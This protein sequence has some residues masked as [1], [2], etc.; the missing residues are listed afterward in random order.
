MTSILQSTLPRT[1]DASQ[2]PLHLRDYWHVILRRRRLVAIVFLLIVAAGAARVLLVKRLYQ[3]T[4]Q[5]LIERQLPNVL[6]FENSTVAKE[7]WEDFYQTQYRLLQSRL[8]ARKVIERLN[9][10]QDPDF[11]DPSTPVAPPPSATGTSPAMEMLIDTFLDRLKVEPVKNSQLLT[12]GFRSYRPQLAAQVANTLTQIYIQQVL[13]FHNSTSAETGAWL[14]G[15]T[16]EQARKVEEAERALQKF[17]EG[18]G[19]VNIEERRT[20]LEQKLKDLGSSLT[21]AKTRRLDK[22]ALYRQMRSSANPEE[23]PEVI[24]SG[25][26]QSLRSE[27][28][29]LERQGAQLTAKGYLEQHPEVVKVREQIDA[30]RQKIAAE[31][32]RFVRGAENDYRVAADQERSVAAALES[33][34]SE[35]L[36]LSQRSLK[37]DS[38]KRDLDASKKLSDNMLTREKE[39]NV[40][41][42]AEVS[43]VRVVDA[44]AEP[45]DP[46]R[47]RPIRDT[48]LSI[49]LGLVLAVGAAFFRDY[50]DNSVG[51]P[52]D[53]RR[54]GLPLLGIIPEGNAKNGG[55]V[56]TNG[57]RK[58]P[59]SEGYRVLRAA[60]HGPAGQGQV[61]V[62]T[63]TLP[64]EGKSLTAVNLALSLASA[65]ERVLLVDADMRRPTLNTLLGM[66]RTPGLCE[67]LTGVAGLEAAVQRVPGTRLRILT[68]GTPVE[69]NPADLLATSGFRE[70]LMTLRA[71]YDRIVLDTPP[72]GALAD[73]LTLSPL[74][75][76]VLVVAR[77]GKVT[78]SALSQALERLAQAR[79]HVVGVVLNRARPERHQYDYGPYFERDAFSAKGGSHLLLP[80]AKAH[81]SPGRHH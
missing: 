70:L 69:S 21:A 35:A 12:V 37:Y 52:S 40:A 11:V 2:E 81:S 66:R 1:D 56:V 73:A 9:L 7:M 72:A 48:A 50:L 47:P 5:I 42:N 76:G 63:S 46:V 10:L 71:S 39:T 78:G 34:K 68:A 6:D 4:V 16:E 32:R 29:T 23:L 36:D 22:E 8:L 20:L 77:C 14:G 41:R 53:V 58:E 24:A 25:F 57:H 30:T 17:N 65:D 43:N 15:K 33:A 27:L 13:E 75:E 19:L 79:A 31:A 67:V 49:V 18:E 74:A 61:L 60:L 55:L 59:F 80:E 45:Q 64:G 3:G 51:K 26:I 38:L 62:V 54:L 28:A 44:A